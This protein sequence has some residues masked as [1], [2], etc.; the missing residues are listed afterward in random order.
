MSNI[1]TSKSSICLNMI[2]RNEAHIIKRCLESVI[3]YINT[4]VIA[5]TGSTD[6]T[7]ALIRESLKN[8]PGEL[9]EHEWVNFG[10]NRDQV[11]Q[12]SKGKSDYIL[13]IDADEWLE[14][15]AGFDFTNLKADSYYITKNQTDKKYWV[16]NII[17][18]DIG[19]KW[20]GVLHECLTCEN[21]KTEDDIDHAVIQARQEG[22]RAHDPN[23]YRKDAALL[24]QALIDEPGNTRYQFYLA[25]SWRDADDPDQ[26]IIHYKRRIAM[27]G[28]E[29]EVFYS[30][31]QI[32]IAMEK[33]GKPW[34]ECM[35]AYLEAWEHTPE[36]SEPLYK[37]GS[38]YLEQRNWPLAWLF[39]NQAANIKRDRKFLLFI[40]E[41]VYQYTAL[42]DATVAAGYLGYWEEM[43][44]NHKKLMEIEDLSEEVIDHAKKNYA[45]F[46]GAKDEDESVAA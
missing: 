22:A 12:H 17:K 43:E 30:K 33:L 19:W 6:G 41:K 8:I 29:E 15:E 11:L 20:S 10:H 14:C 25:Q 27:G 35:S 44:E 46:M 26:A 23:T 5:D 38:Y 34:N 2:V 18:N 16:R 9:L 7:Q 39:L 37:I 36:R 31:Y 28:W 42:F 3:P 1:E 4:W 40:E 45:Y 21:A 32:A 13:T 24:T